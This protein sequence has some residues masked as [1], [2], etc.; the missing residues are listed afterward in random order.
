[1]LVR[2]KILLIGL[3][4]FSQIISGSLCNGKSLLSWAAKTTEVMKGARISPPINQVLRSA[5]LGSWEGWVS[6]KNSL[7]LSDDSAELLCLIKIISSLLV[8]AGRLLPG[9]GPPE[10]HLTA[11]YL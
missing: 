7:N 4:H 9:R 2:P 6:I 11:I 1:M 5:A 3:F 8:E 10:A